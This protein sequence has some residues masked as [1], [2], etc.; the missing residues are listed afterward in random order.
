MSNRAKA[1]IGLGAVAIA[2]SYLALA[3][4]IDY[5]DADVREIDRDQLFRTTERLLRESEG[6]PAELSD[7]SVVWVMPKVGP[8]TGRAIGEGQWASVLET[9]AAVFSGEQPW[10]ADGF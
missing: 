9:A 10:M 6:W 2:A 7:G 8:G 3:G 4:G 1:A 5:P